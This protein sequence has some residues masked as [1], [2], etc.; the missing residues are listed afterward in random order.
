MMMVAGLHIPRRSSNS[1]L[2][3]LAAL[4]RTL[5]GHAAPQPPEL[6]ELMCSTSGAP[7]D[8]PLLCFMRYAMQFSA[9]SWKAGQATHELAE[10]MCSTSGAG[11]T[12]PLTYPCSLHRHVFLMH[13][14]PSLAILGCKLLDIRV[15]SACDH[16]DRRVR[17]FSHVWQYFAHQRCMVACGGS[18]VFAFSAT[19]A[20]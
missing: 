16:C 5:G 7:A 10:L 19:P 3:R 9:W 2:E 12:Q 4:R 14:R 6:A 11:E 15:Q 20:H 18:C 1:G 17:N 13:S 8:R